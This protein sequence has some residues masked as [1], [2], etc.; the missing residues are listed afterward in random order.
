MLHDPGSYTP[1]QKIREIRLLPVE[2]ETLRGL[3][4]ELAAIAAL[5]VHKEKAGLWRKLND[6]ES[7]RPMV[8][9]NEIPWHEMNVERSSRCGPSIRGPGSWRPVCGA[10]CTSGG[11]C[12]GT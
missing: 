3:A 2:K 11:T 10:P 7:V 12:R 4:R 9:I 6:L 1:P 5:P 8:W